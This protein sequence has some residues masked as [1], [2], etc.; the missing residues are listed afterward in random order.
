MHKNSNIVRL[1]IDN[2]IANTLS[3]LPII[4]FRWYLN[5]FFGG[6]LKIQILKKNINNYS[7]LIEYKNSKI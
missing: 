3:D 6:E 5:T 7:D 1:P 2:I 4:N